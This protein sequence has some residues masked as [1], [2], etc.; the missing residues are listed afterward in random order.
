MN[1][2]YPLLPI[3]IFVLMLYL[4]SGL[5]VR[6][7]IISQV[8][9]RKLWNSLLL[10]AFMVTATLG[11]LQTVQINYKL[12]WP[13]TKTLL[14][15]HVDFGIALGCIGTFHFLWNRKYYF[16]IFN[17]DEGSYSREVVQN[18]PQN[19]NV[20]HLKLLILL[21][22]FLS[23]TIQVLL[24]RE[25][26][27]VFQ[28]NELMMSWTLG[29]WML[30]T[31]VGTWLGRSQVNHEKAERDLVRMLLLMASLPVILVPMLD[32]LKTS[33]FLPGVMVNPGYFLLILIIFLAPVCLITGFIY[34]LLVNAFRS[35]ETWFT[36]VY[37]LEAAGSLIGGLVVSFIFVQ[38]ISVIQSL[39][40]LMLFS[41]IVLTFIRKTIKSIITVTIALIIIAISAIFQLDYRLKSSLFNN[42]KVLDSRETYYGNITVSEN[43]G[44]YNFFENG[45][46]LYT[47]DNTITSEEYT[48][49]ALMQHKDPKD[50]LL[51][52]GGLAGMVSEILKYSSVENVD[53]IEM[54]PQL[55]NMAAKYSPLPTDKRV[56]FIAG[57]GR[58]YI[59]QTK[60]KYNIVIFA[61]P[62]PSSLQINRF[63]TN[64]LLAIL[65]EKLQPGAVILY[66]ISSSGN[67]MSEEKTGIETAVYHT[68]MNN[69]QHVEII[70]GERD[71]F[72]A[73]DSILRIDIALLS[74]ARKINTKYVNSYYIDDA[75]IL[76]RGKA[77]KDNLNENILNL[78]ERPSPVYFHTLQFISE[79]TSNGWLLI[80]IPVILLLIPLLFMRSVAAGMYITG[81][82]AASFEIL[83]IFTFQTFFGY[84]YSAI[85]LIIALF[86]GGLSLGSIIGNH[87]S[88]TNKHFVA[89]QLLLFL[90]AVLFPVFWYGQK[91]MTN[92]FIGLILFG[93]ITLILSAIVGFQ[94]VIGTKLLPGKFTQTASLLYAVDLIGA[95]LGVI[96]ISVILLPLAGVFYSCLIIAV[97]N[98]LI[99]FFKIINRT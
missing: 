77:I 98:L 94:Y 61:V 95:A 74:T 28:G 30:L 89:A 14:L 81:F 12:E 41:A 43:G 36:K 32:I 31:G 62:D 79:F 92:G 56:H 64:E 23:T 20:G 44:Q 78:D 65:K 45:S 85:G 53:Y 76:Q 87:F 80:S 97:F 18:N 33:L 6:L 63:Y 17:S 22:G 51:V 49:Y 34:S 58:R 83:I 35:E 10:I 11:I 54:N 42:Q 16:K 39:L 99:A 69:F 52:S 4:L 1:T 84:V 93:L 73:S 40:V 75:S 72:I 2:P 9:H 26:A 59:Q 27:T 29:A 86:M 8:L 13:L 15:W 47:T 37:A 21:S 90:Y 60:K 50:I 82:T 91:V 71:Y 25:I 55:I 67:Y 19:Q 24:I 57:D 46:L 48:H 68:L 70:P 66:G 7:K 88:A 3:G 38:W 96:V 5:L